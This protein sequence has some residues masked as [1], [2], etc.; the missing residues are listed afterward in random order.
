MST[1]TE[2][3]T[4]I[5]G[6][7][8]MVSARTRGWRER[9]KNARIYVELDDAYEA[10]FR[11]VQ[12]VTP[13]AF[14]HLPLPTYERD[15]KMVPHVH[16]TRGQIPELDKAWDAANRDWIRMAREATV[17][18]LVG[19]GLAVPTLR[20]SKKAGCS[21]PCS[22]GFIATSGL[23]VPDMGDNVDVWVTVNADYLAKREAKAETA[24]IKA[25]VDEIAAEIAAAGVRV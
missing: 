5:N 19:A 1:H 4:E 6:H 25:M 24:R 9:A 7:K 15:G 22:P 13:E 18:G 3:F 10:E 23:F 12:P 17:A 16:T 14:A 8:A 21:C 11:R 2:W 20:F